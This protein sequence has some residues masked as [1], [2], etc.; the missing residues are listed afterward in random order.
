MQLGNAHLLIGCEPQRHLRSEIF[1]KLNSTLRSPKQ[2]R[3]GAASQT[4]DSNISV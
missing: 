2:A 4:A 3:F 1:L